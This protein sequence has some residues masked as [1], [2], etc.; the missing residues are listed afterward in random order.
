VDAFFV[1]LAVVFVAE[2]G[3]KSQLMA[4]AAAARHS[5][6]VVLGGIAVAACAVHLLSVLAGRALAEA[7]S[8]TAATVAAGLAFLGF[9]LWTLRGE[10]DDEAVDPAARRS[11]L[12]AAAAVAAT[13]FASEIG[14]KTMLATAALAAR[15]GA[16]PTWAGATLGMVTA[17]AAAIVVGR[18]LA[19]RLSSRTIRLASAAVFA[20]FGVLLVLQALL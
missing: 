9:A 12:A 1:T 17:D 6:V 20:L 14:D 5:A 16:V 15:Q 7:L 2:L 10:D 8:G 18:R 11:G 13:F 3:D 4:V 19:A